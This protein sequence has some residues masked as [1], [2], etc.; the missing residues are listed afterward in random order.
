[1]A[2]DVNKNAHIPISRAI[3]PTDI[4]P[5]PIRTNSTLFN[6]SN[7]NTT[8]KV[9]CQTNT[10]N[11]NRPKSPKLTPTTQYEATHQVTPKTAYDTQTKHPKTSNMDQQKQNQEYKQNHEVNHQANH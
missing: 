9:R 5:A 10:H 1:M 6:K 2:N 11:Q 8:V 4:N 7:L 3:L